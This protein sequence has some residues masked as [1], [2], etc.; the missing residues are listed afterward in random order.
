MNRNII[1]VI[2]GFLVI[3]IAVSFLAYTY[4]VANVKKLGGY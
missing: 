2:V 3:A 1:E 4:K